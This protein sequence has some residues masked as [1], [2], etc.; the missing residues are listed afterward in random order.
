MSSI[1]DP[2]LSAWGPQE[3]TCGGPE[4]EYFSRVFCGFRFS[5][6]RRT[7]IRLLC[8]QYQ[9][10][11]SPF[12][13]SLRKPFGDEI[14]NRLPHEGVV[15]FRFRD[16]AAAELLLKPLPFPSPALPNLRS[17][18]R[19]EGGTPTGAKISG[20]EEIFFRRIG[21]R[22]IIPDLPLPAGHDLPSNLS[23][24]AFIFRRQTGSSLWPGWHRIWSSHR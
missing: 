13:S 16:E 9:G 18:P 10:H 6:V 4:N 12:R 3:M 5:L 14:V 2:Q 23:T 7:S 17:D 22:P 21:T 20:D 11:F 8:V 19:K 24:K 1:V 15:T